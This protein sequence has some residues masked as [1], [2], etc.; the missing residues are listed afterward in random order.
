MDNS[1]NSPKKSK[2]KEDFK[3]N[4]VFNKNGLTFMEYIEKNYI[5]YVKKF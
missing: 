5:D 2:P 4:F 1:N 3:V